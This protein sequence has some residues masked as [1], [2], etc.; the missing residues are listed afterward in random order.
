ML[1]VPPL[2][3][4]MSVT[5]SFKN[6]FSF[7]V[8]IFL[9]FSIDSEPIWPYDPKF[10]GYDR[11]LDNDNIKFGFCSAFTSFWHIFENDWWLLKNLL[12]SCVAKTCKITAKPNNIWILWSQMSLLVCFKSYW[13]RINRKIM[14]NLK[15][16]WFV[17]ETEGH[18]HLVQ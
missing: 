15:K 17:F 12:F 16:I 1:T 11:L 3:D 2:L 9:N 10:A 4:Q 5:L 18:W 8:Q 13:G 7:F 14:Q 6:N